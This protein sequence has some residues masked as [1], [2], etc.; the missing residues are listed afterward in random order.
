MNVNE[1]ISK[2]GEPRKV[3]ILGIDG[4]P[5]YNW[6]YEMR[7]CYEWWDGIGRIDKLDVVRERMT[8]VEGWLSEEYFE[9]NRTLRGRK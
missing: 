8:V 4:K 9:K 6:L 7:G 5:R 1:Y 2:N 3:H